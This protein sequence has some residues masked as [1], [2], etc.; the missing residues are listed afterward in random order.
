MQ[1]VSY[2]Y[3]SIADINDDVYRPEESALG[4]IR[5]AA[6]KR[7]KPGEGLKRS[8]SDVDSEFGSFSALR[9]E[10]TGSANKKRKLDAQDGDM[11]D[12][13]DYHAAGEYAPLL[14]HAMKLAGA[15][16]KGKGK[17]QRERSID[18]VS[19]TTNTKATR[20][21]QPARRRLDAFPPETLDALGL[22]NASASL[23]TDTTPA[24]S[25][26]SSPAL[27]NSAIVYD[28]EEEKPPLKKA[29]KVDDAQM[30]KRVKNLEDAQRKVWTNI[31]RRDVAKARKYVFHSAPKC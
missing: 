19:T 27:P 17:L 31:A 12:D 14:L 11:T 9:K 21:R 7:S 5:P 3:P 1:Q 16:G 23:S 29:K 22:G 6:R 2:D 28:L 25:R 15:S 24:E 10:A 30:M 20:K 4:Q 8:A 18:S 13:V 26:V